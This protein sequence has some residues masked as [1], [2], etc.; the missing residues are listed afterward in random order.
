LRGIFV[1]VVV[2]VAGKTS[3]RHYIA[4]GD[5]V[6]DEEFEGVFCKT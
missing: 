2:K 1:V 4:R 6:D 5:V 3:R